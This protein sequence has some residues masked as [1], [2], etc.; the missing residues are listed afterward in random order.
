MKIVRNTKNKALVLEL[1]QN[2]GTA[3]SAPDILKER[4]AYVIK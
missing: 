2:M 4:L 1:I 3:I